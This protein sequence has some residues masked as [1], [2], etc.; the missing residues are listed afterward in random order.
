MTRTIH[1]V[2]IH[3]AKHIVASR[4]AICTLASVVVLPTCV[5]AVV[6]NTVSY[7]IRGSAT[8]GNF[9]TK[10]FEKSDTRSGHEI[11]FAGHSANASISSRSAGAEVTITGLA[12]AING[13][14]FFGIRGRVSGGNSDPAEMASAVIPD[15]Y[16]S[17]RWQDSVVLSLP[18]ASPPGRLA[19]VFASLTISNADTDFVKAQGTVAAARD[20]SAEFI[21]DIDGE[22]VPTGPF[23]GHFAVYYD[24]LRH[25]PSINNPPPTVIPIVIEMVDGEPHAIDYS[26]SLSLNAEVYSA[27]STSGSAYVEFEKGYQN[28]L[29]W[30]GITKV[31]DAATGI[32]IEGWTITSESGRDYARPAPEPAAL[33]LVAIAACL[34]LLYPRL[35]TRQV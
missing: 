13:E 28:I 30:G 2:V 26:V 25:S 29:R 17:S 35:D 3:S 27:S 5:Q 33:N 8:T 34:F 18:G 7:N 1:S 24:N 19:H 22:G 31:T 12:A 4:L 11:A 6:L 16:V 9:N 10:S 21:M 32:A 14:L 15:N 20:V 23:G